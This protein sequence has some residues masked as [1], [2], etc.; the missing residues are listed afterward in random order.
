MADIRLLWTPETLSADIVPSYPGLDDSGELESAVAISLFTWRRAKDDDRV[1]NPNSLL[2]RQGWWGDG[3]S[4]WQ[5][6]EFP[7]PIGSRLWLLSRE[8]MTVETIQRA[9]EYAEEALVWLVNDKVATS[10]SVS[11]V[12]NR[13][14]PHR[15]DMS[16]EILR[17]NGQVLNLEYDNVWKQI[18]GGEKQ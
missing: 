15:T 10:V 9:K 13:L 8:K 4:A 1:D 5:S 6:G 17:E 7:D 11:V 18:S 16:V 14:N 12:R 3:F 2:S